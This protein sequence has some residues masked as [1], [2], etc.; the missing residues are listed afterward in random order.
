MGAN[1]EGLSRLYRAND[2]CLISDA[3]FVSIEC[4]TGCT[5]RVLQGVNTC[6][7]T[8]VTCPGG[9]TYVAKE[10]SSGLLASDK[11]CKCTTGLAGGGGCTTMGFNGSCPPGFYPDGAGRCCPYGGG[12]CNT[13]IPCSSDLIAQDSGLPLDGSAQCCQLSPI[14]IDTSGNGFAFTAAQNGVD[15]DFDGDGI[16]HQLSWTVANS[17]DAW[18]VLDRND[19]GGI[20]DGTELFGNITPQPQSAQPNG[21]LALAE[22]DKAEKGGN[23]DGLMDSRDAIFSSLQLW[24]DVNHNGISEANELHTLPELGVDAI[25]LDYKESKR[26]DE[27]GNQFRYRAKVDDARHSHVGRWAWDV[28]LQIAH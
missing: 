23:S 18:L 8:G 20:D 26:V 6:V 17:D 14:V 7:K 1:A 2:T 10:C 4:V 25:A 21:F 16:K 12:E 27:F 24:Q 9:I 13:L 15:F 22:Y 5:D 3:S 19:N 28:F 11:P